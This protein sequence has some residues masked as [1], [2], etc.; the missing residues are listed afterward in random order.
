MMQGENENSRLTSSWGDHAAI[1]MVPTSAAPSLK[2]G[3]D[4]HSYTI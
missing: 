1:D 4:S 3:G 2:S